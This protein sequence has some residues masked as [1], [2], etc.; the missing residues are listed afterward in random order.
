M[1]CKDCIY[2]SGIQCQGH[3]DYFGR[4]QLYDALIKYTSK[5]ENKSIYD[6]K[7]KHYTNSWDDVVYDNT[8]CSII[9]L[10]K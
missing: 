9:E 2:Y 8:D 10:I 6:Y 3:G 7:V 4:C 1:K 5:V